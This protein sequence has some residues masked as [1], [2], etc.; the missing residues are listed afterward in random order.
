[1][2]ALKSA[3]WDWIVIGL[4]GVI[5]ITLFS[6]FIF[7]DKMLSGT[8]MV[9][10]GYMMRKV[11]ADYW[12]ANGT[13][14][15]WDP[16]ILA[17]LPV[18][19]A[20]HGDLFYPVSIFYVLMPL[21]KALGYKIILHVWVA[22][23]AM[24]F[25][26]KTLGLRRRAC[27][28]GAVGYMV[29]PYFLSLI[30]AGHDAKMFVT[31]LFPLCVMLLERLIR[32]VRLLESALFGA[33]IGL[34]L[35][36]AHPQMAYF[37]A[38][39]LGLYFILNIPRIIAKRT[40]VKAVALLMLAIVLGAGIG[41]IQFLPTYNYTTN[42]SPRTGGVTL[43]FA[44]SWSLHPEEIVSL[45]Y[46]SFA[47][48]LDDYWG[49]NFF[50]L[51]A[52]SPGPLVFILALCGFVFFLRRRDML[53]WLVLFIFCP[54]YAL[55]AH[56]PV[57][58]IVF[59]AVPGAK[60][61][62]AP[63]VIMFMFSCAS[64]VLAAYFV[65]AFLEKKLS[66]GQ[67]RWLMGIVLGTLV[68]TIIFTVGRGAFLGLWKSVFGW[69]DRQKLEIARRASGSWPAD[70]ILV[71]VFIWSSIGLARTSY[72][73]KW[74]GALW[75]GILVVG[76]LVTGLRHSTR[77]IEYIEVGDFVRKDP[78]IEYV[79]KDK[80]RFRVLPIT[81]WSFYNRNYLPIFGIETANGF[82]DNRIR[83]YDTLIG[84]NQANLLQ[85]NIMRITNIKYVLT[86]ERISHPMLEPRQDFGRAF[87]YENKGFLERAFIVHNAL[88]VDDDVSALEIMKS[89][90][91]DP[92][93]TIVLPS[94]EAMAGGG[95]LPAERATI[96]SDDP[97]GVVI[98]ARLES[99]GYL[100]YSGNYLPYWKAYVDG[101]ETPVE[102][103]DIS[104]RA[105]RLS[106]G[107]HRITMKYD[108]PW[109][110]LGTYLCLGC[111]AVVGLLIAAGWWRARERKGKWL[112]SQ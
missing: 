61:L 87:V 95:V 72:R 64:S 41:C 107:E 24:Y 42:F 38:W 85:P 83:F 108:S 31:A 100:F 74:A 86:S 93:T 50:K 17:G 43:E 48:Y 94:G 75:I 52:E 29:A 28:V 79:N 16:Y 96:E 23:I 98:Q 67:K 12:K 18:V 69:P 91:F 101:N 14:P 5:V 19:D 77:F 58:K 90:D 4:L 105:V 49:R 3:R 30:Y 62:R 109:F 8:D 44:S 63:S 47:G 82:Y 80:G 59:H 34:L 76:I 111:C 102:R 35:L 54:L 73:R 71:A 32:K 9:P 103:C 33:S 60:F 15:L 106:R 36:A 66:E 13:I 51:N 20:M 10:M 2:K 7:S 104:M 88:V 57:L 39:G 45:L 84:E 22:G 92:S 99:D 81:G 11:V 53:P 40:V 1:M 65:N 25:L 112:A 56:T 70:A 78:M 110:R 37:A 46:P 6:G 26:L 89:S 21:H 97:N 27:L 55:G 68:L